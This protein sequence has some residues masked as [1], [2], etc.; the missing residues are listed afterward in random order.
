[1]RPAQADPAEKR[2]RELREAEDARRAKALAEIE[3]AANEFQRL[4]AKTQASPD[5]ELDALLRNFPQLANSAPGQLC[6]FS[7]QRLEQLRCDCLRVM[8]TDS[9]DPQAKLITMM[10]SAVREWWTRHGAGEAS[11]QQG[12]VAIEPMLLRAIQRIDKADA[13]GWDEWNI[14]TNF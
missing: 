8:P 13:S 10:R 9:R 2:L 14:V 12:L 4:L 5:M 11:I 1:M 7:P 6:M 3:Q